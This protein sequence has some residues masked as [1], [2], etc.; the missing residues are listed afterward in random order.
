MWAPASTWASASAMT[1]LI[2][3]G[4]HLGG[5]DL[6]AGGVDA[7]ADDDEGAVEAD[8]DFAGG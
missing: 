6:A 7:F 2:V 4:H 3:A 8:H 5:Q 1:R